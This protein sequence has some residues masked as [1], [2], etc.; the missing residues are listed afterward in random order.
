MADL[1]IAGADHSK[2]GD[3]PATL[4]NMIVQVLGKDAHPYDVRRIRRLWDDEVAKSPVD[5]LD[6]QPLH[7]RLER[8]AVRLAKK[9]GRH[10]F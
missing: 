4:N 5:P 7:R 6:G 9:M 3:K 10:L 8:A 2:F 1:W